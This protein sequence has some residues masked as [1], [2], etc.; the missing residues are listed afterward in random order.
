[1]SIFFT[2]SAFL[3]NFVTVAAAKRSQ[4]AQVRSRGRNFG[5]FSPNT[6]FMLALNMPNPTRLSSTELQEAARKDG[7][8]EEILSVVRLFQWLL[9]GLAVNVAFL[10]DQLQEL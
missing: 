6:R 10:R 1:M 7:P 3:S 4:A 8:L 2:L 5:T 9:P